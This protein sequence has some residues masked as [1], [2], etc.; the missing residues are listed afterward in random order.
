MRWN[1]LLTAGF[2]PVDHEFL[3]QSSDGPVGQPGPSELNARV[4]ESPSAAITFGG[5]TAEA[6]AAQSAS[7]A[8]SVPATMAARSSRRKVVMVSSL[9]P[10][11]RGGYHRLCAGSR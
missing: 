3:G 11:I 1:W 7:A 2:V 4:I 5:A 6:G 10:G 8:R 9:K